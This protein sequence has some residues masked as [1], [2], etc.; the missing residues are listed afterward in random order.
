MPAIAPVEDQTGPSLRIVEAPRARRRRLKPAI[1]RLEIL[2]AAARAMRRRGARTTVE[3][4]AHEAG[5]ARGTVYLY[6]PTWEAL[7]LELRRLVLAEF[8][9]RAAR[10]AGAP[11]DGDWLGQAEQLA[12]ALAD[13]LLGLGGLREALFHAPGLPRRLG[14]DADAPIARLL[15]AGA[16]AGLLAA[17]D[18]EATARLICA[19]AHAAADAI[20]AGER[21]P[22]VLAALGELVRRAVAR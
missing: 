14:Q 9:L 7:V 20:A 4:V 13:F 18:P 12:R 3:D 2:V 16:D 10:L 5:A 11:A 22:R 6:F 17:A 1:R 8:D 21:R 19:A 15:V